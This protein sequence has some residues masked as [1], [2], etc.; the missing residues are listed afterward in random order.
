MVKQTVGLG[1]QGLGWLLTLTSGLVLA[2][3]S[4]SHRAEAQIMDPTEPADPTVPAPKAPAPKAP[5][6]KAPAP[7]T[8]AAGAEDAA[9]GGDAAEG[10]GDAGEEEVV[11][12]EPEPEPTP[13]PEPPPV[14]DDDSNALAPSTRPWLAEFGVGPNIWMLACGRTGFAGGFGCTSADGTTQVKMRQVVGYHFSGDGEGFAMG[15]SLEEAFGSSVFRFQ[16]GLRLWG[17]IPVADDLAVYV[18]PYGQLGYSLWHVSF[19][20]FGSATAHFFNWQLGA[21]ARI[22]LGDRWELS[23]TPVGFD[24]AANDDG[25]LW[26]YDISFGFG[27]T[28]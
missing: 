15:L 23:F 19:G 26:T 11:E 21:K 28:F 14:E 9:G 6:P 5:S 20:G 17:D 7:T 3:L 22:V 24:W 27:A 4:S 10:G 1:R 25:M 2:G 16:P 18:T 13:A 12:P 8:T